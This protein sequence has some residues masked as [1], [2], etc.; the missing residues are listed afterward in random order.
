MTPE[1]RREQNAEK[2]I[3]SFRSKIGDFSNIL[4]GLK[5]G[6]DL[7]KNLAYMAE[8]EICG[9]DSDD[10]KD[11]DIDEDDELPTLKN[12]DTAVTETE[13]AQSNN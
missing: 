12:R 3:A 1:A 4:I 8:Q 11:F 13:S 9:S 5:T 10:D 7:L 2:L 6:P